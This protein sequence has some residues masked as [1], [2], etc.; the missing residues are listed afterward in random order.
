MICRLLLIE[1]LLF[2]GGGVAQSANVL[3][4]LTTLRFLPEEA[5][6]ATK[7]HCQKQLPKPTKTYQ[8]LP[9]AASPLTLA[10]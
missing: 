5:T 4:V 10:A 8:N 2:C 7:N 9:K 3:K 6:E 1:G